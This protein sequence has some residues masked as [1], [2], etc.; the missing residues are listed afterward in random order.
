VD[1]FIFRV[2][3]YPLRF[4]DNHE[5]RGKNGGK[6]W[7]IK[8]RFAGKEKRLSLGVY[9]AVGLKEA[10]NRTAEVKDM[11]RQGLDPGEERK[12]A[13]GQ[14]F[15]TVAREWCG[16][17][18]PAWS[19]GHQKH[20]L[21]RLENQLFPYLG[22]APLAD[23]KAA[24]FL[25]AIRKAEARGTIET[26]HRLAQLCDQVTRYARISGIVKQDA[27]AGLTETLALVQTRH[28]AAITDPAAIGVSGY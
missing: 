20:I 6:W 27:A 26:V 2:R 15:D 4:V 8:Y 21:H 22:K 24:D 16:K 5:K 25:A 11:L 19:S 12:A 7:R 28:H 10:R 13:R 3:S 23:L 1:F 18:C 17:K 14:T 9:S